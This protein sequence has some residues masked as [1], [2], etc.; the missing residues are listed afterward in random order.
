MMKD[1]T[2]AIGEFWQV[3]LEK[4]EELEEISA[5]YDTILEHLQKIHPGIYCE[6]FIERSHDDFIKWFL[7]HR[8]H[9][10]KKRCIA[11]GNGIYKQRNIIKNFTCKLKKFFSV[12]SKHIINSLTI[13]KSVIDIF[14][15]RN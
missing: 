4:I 13:R 8:F 3:F 1:E 11:I 6:F 14:I 9:Q 2:Q 5:A 12:F 15:S 10:L 7:Y